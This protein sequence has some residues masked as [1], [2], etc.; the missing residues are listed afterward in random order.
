MTPEQKAAYINAKVSLLNAEIAM[1]EAEN[2]NRITCGNS[3]AY[4]GNEFQKVIDK[5][6]CVLGENEVW[7][8]FHDN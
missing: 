1:M 5:Y 4:D 7:R 2:I 6:E 3:I 8:L